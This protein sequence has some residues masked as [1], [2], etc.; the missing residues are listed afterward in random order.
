[1]ANSSPSARLSSRNRLGRTPG[2]LPDSLLP[3]L[4]SGG[5]GAGW[6][7]QGLA[8]SRQGLSQS[9]LPRVQAG[10][11]SSQAL[12]PEAHAASFL[13]AGVARSSPPQGP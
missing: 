9:L 7:L 1:M 3:V 13:G 11:T 10:L 5:M 8:E 12:A 6:V 4:S 2:S